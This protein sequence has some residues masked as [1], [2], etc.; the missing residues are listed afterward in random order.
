MVE[1]GFAL[2]V[3]GLLCGL[4][5]ALFWPRWGLVSRLR[6]LTRQTERVR[7]E[8][9]LKQLYKLEYASMPATVESVAGGT[10]L[11][12][13]RTMNL[14]HRLETLDFVIHGDGS[15]HLTDPGRSYALR[16]LRTHRLWERF[17]ADRTGVRPSDWHREAERQEHTLSPSATEDLAASLGHPVYDPHG[18]PIPTAQ[19]MMPDRAG[20]GLGSLRPGEVARIIHLEDEPPE[21]FKGLVDA[22]LAPGQALEGLPSQKG[23]VRFRVEGEEKE[24]TSLAAHN[25][26]VE[27]GEESELP[28]FEN[29][30]ADLGPGDAATVV[31]ISPKYQGPSRRRLL[32]LGVVP[33]TLITARMRSAGG[34]PMAYDIRGALIALRKEQAAMV[35]VEGLTRSGEK[36]DTAMEALVRSEAS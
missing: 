13:N 15:F 7:L 17:L 22:G 6:T 27:L 23:M 19:G 12:R 8:D 2:L 5:A 10:Q 31:G 34:D 1:P 36:S 9:V 4:C 21:V 3:F 20:F 11:G 18:D 14:L 35:H 25:V 28:A 29:T 16:I 30:L 33:G 26:T 32:D 24:L